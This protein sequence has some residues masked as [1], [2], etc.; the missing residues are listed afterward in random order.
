MENNYFNFLKDDFFESREYMR[1]PSPSTSRLFM[2]TDSANNARVYV[3][4][5]DV[6][7]SILIGRV[8]MSK[9]FINELPHNIHYI[10]KLT[11]VDEEQRLEL[12]DILKKF[13]DY[14]KIR[15][16]SRVFRV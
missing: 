13:K 5:Q 9:R 7:K 6:V 14:E 1:Q 10:K 16:E 11:D 15:S 2:Y 4:L 8:I 3:E 12:A